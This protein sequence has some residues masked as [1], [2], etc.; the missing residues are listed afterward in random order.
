MKSATSAEIKSELK[1]SSPTRL[2]ELCLRL[3]RFKKENKELLTFLLFEADDLPVYIQ[4][5][6]DEM[7]LEFSQVNSRN[8]YQ[9]KKTLRKIL[10]SANKY[11]RYIGNTTAE[12]EI[13]L[14]YAIRFSELQLPFHRSAALVNLYKGQIKKISTAISDLH[15]DLQYDYQRKLDQ[16]EEL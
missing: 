13:L 14:H 9:A 5:I 11:I 7:D 1:K 4:N 6:R 8:L 15:E 3:A 16:L 12:V 2:V 10:R